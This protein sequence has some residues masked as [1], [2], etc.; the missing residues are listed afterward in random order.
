[1][2]LSNRRRRPGTPSG[3]GPAESPS[4]SPTAS[5][6]SGNAA[7]VEALD[8]VEQQAP[9][10]GVLDLFATTDQEQ[11]PEDVT[12]SRLDVS[13]K[14]APEP[15][16]IAFHPTRGTLF[17]VGDRG[18]V[19]E[20][21][22]EG[23]ILNRERI[24]KYDLEGI[25]VGPDGTLF[26]TREGGPKILEIDPDSLDVIRKI[27]VDRKHD[28]DKVVQ[29][30]ENEGLEGIVWVASRDAFYAVNQD[31]PAALLRLSMP[32]RG[33]ERDAEIEEVIPLK[34]IVED[35]ASDVTFDPTS[36]NFLITES[37]DE[38]GLLHVV[39]PAG[40]HVETRQLPGD[41]TEGFAIAD[42]GSAYVAEDD[43]PIRH[44]QR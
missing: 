25:T 16:G 34:D 7:T 2:S 27:D 29:K 8:G 10:P 20:M 22:R 35:H 40:E 42:D 36:G 4:S 9:E 23:E 31:H 41:S 24:E 12:T 14:K 43:G 5:T 17:V 19:I 26:A 28:G 38:G 11:G 44:V 37:R 6:G 32:E 15:S 39:T 1:M 33:D 13:K 3:S 30:R 21:T 18:H